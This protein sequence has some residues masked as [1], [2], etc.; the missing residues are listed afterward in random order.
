MY[1]RKI[2]LLLQEWKNQS[3][4]KPLIIKGV[5]Q[6]GKTSS[7]LAFAKANYK[8]VVYLDFRAYPEYKQ[9]FYPNLDI[10]AIVMRINAAL[11]HVVIEPNSTCFVFDEIQDCPIARSSLKYF[12]LDGR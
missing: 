10:N 12:S 9:I 2:E 5:R 3:K 7:V 6:C 11:P 1:K 8:H 4:R